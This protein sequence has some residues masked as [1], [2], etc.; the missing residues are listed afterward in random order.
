METLDSH[1]EQW[2]GVIFFIILYGSILFF[3]PFYKKTQKKPA[4]AFF[5][6]ILAFAI[7]MHGIPFSM[8]LIG[9]IFGRTLPEGILWGHTFIK[10]IGFAGMYINIVLSLSGLFMIINGWYTIYH[11]YWKK[12]DGEGKVVK[13]RDIPL[14]P[15]P[16][17]RRS[18]PDL[19]GYAGRMGNTSNIDFVSDYHLDVQQTCQKRGRGYVKRIWRG[20]PNVYE[21][22]KTVHPVYLV[23]RMNMKEII[24][25]MLLSFLF[26]TGIEGLVIFFNREQAFF[27]YWLYF[28][29]ALAIL[30]VL[31]ITVM[32]TGF[33]KLKAEEPG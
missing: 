4:G 28:L 2:W 12:V 18:F 7:E 1:F 8:Y 9:I 17:I 21:K 26:L 30:A 24:V 14:Y 33:L 15:T 13:K 22:H 20:I 3:L 31:L 6:F 16:P 23:R 10:Q 11:G 5:A 29:I 19:N 32:I 25:R 27:V